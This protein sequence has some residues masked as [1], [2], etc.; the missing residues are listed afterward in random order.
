MPDNSPRDYERT[1]LRFVVHVCRPE[2]S[3]TPAAVLHARFR[4]Q[5]EAML[6]E[7][8]DGGVRAI[9]LDG[10]D[11]EAAW[12]TVQLG[13]PV[14]AIAAAFCVD[15]AATAAGVSIPGGHIR[16]LPGDL[17]VP[18]SEANDIPCAAA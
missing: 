1:I 10:F 5:L 2:G 18:V 14:R 16:A 11:E 6:S 8:F 12:Y 13:E 9:A 17:A 7:R 3:D 4:V 15:A